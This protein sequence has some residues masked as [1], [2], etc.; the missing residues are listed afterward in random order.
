MVH[1]AGGAQSP[2]HTLVGGGW[3]GRVPEAG[4]LK[5]VPLNVLDRVDLIG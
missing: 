1:P 3:D 5:A 2:S 4:D